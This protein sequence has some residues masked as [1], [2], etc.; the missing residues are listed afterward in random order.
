VSTAAVHKS[1]A[2]RAIGAF[3]LVLLVVL[4]LGLTRAVPAMHGVGVIAAVGCLLLGGNLLAELAEGFGIP[5]LTGYLLAGILAGPHVIALVDHHTVE[6]LSQVNTLALAL[7]ALAGGAELEL[8]ALKKGLKSLAIATVLQSAMGIVL[9]S[10][11]FI[12]ARP[13]IP[14]AA[15]LE[16][17]ALIAAALCWGVLATVRSPSAALGVLSQ[18]KAN[19]PLALFS[20]NFIMTSD[21]VSVVLLAAAL[22]VARPLVEPGAELTLEAFR[23]L[24]HELLGA[25][26]LGVTLGLLL[27]LYLRAVGKQTLLVLVAI[28]F[29]FTEVL[30]YL[31]F[32]PLLTFMVAGFVVRNLSK[33]GPPL[34]HEIE[35]LGS[36]V[37]VLF[38][39][40][41]GAHLDIPLVRSMWMVALLLFMLRMGA[42][43]SAGRLAAR[44]AKDPPVLKKYGWTGLVSQAGLALG[45]AAVV[46]RQFPSFGAGFRALAIACVALNEMFGPVLFKAAL[47]RT[48]E[49]RTG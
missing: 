21:V 23:E 31:G 15:N 35:K 45:A 12:L 2:S 11:A 20:L 41:A 49:T 10:I 38:F 44:L 19:G 48:G 22:T 9:V 34:L 18:T 5:H 8:G 7:I 30:R 27:A 46:E 14:F 28:G 24:G 13:L 47:D 42:T 36:I 37:Y 32:D 4:L 33:Q 16:T 29:G 39:A 40:I 26:S 1:N 6:D 17:K 43:W 25:V 3:A